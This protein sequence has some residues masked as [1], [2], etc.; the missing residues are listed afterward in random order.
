MWRNERFT[1]AL[2][3]TDA[4]SSGAFT[5]AKADGSSMSTVAALRLKIRTY[6]PPTHSSPRKALNLKCSAGWRS[7]TV[8][9]GPRARSTS[10]TKSSSSWR[11]DTFQIIVVF[12]TFW[13]SARSRSHGR[14]LRSSL[15]KG[16]V[17]RM[18][19]ARCNGTLAGEASSSNMTPA[20]RPRAWGCKEVVAD[21]QT[22][23]QAGHKTR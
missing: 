7:S 15:A 18:A 6:T 1:A 10:K 11:I 3:R 22:D 17:R 20:R 21:R 12:S 5:W 13:L 16:C 8:E 19:R 23:R 9:P 4:S 2:E 14:R